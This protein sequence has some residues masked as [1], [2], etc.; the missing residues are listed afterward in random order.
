VPEEALSD[1]LCLSPGNTTV[2]QYFFRD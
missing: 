2:E 1:W